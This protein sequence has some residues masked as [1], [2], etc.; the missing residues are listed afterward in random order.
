[1][2]QI[3][4]SVVVPCFNEEKNISELVNRCLALF[5]KKEISGEIILVN[6][7]SQDNT[8][9]CIDSLSSEYVRGIHSKTNKG[10]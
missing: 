10:I 3:E 6:D 2:K 4:L 1:M 7:G 8:G 9:S 5:N